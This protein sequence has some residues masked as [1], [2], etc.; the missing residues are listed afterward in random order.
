MKAGRQLHIY[1]TVTNDLTYDQRMH[2]ICGSLAAEGYQVTLVGRKLKT[3]IP[4]E[5][6][7]YKQKR[8]RCFFNKGFLFYKEY[9]IR[10]FFYL[11]SRKM[12]GICAIDLDTIL[13]ALF[14]SKLK[15][16]KRIYDAHEYFTE[17]KEVRTRPLVKWFWTRVEKF[18]IPKFAN[19]YTVSEGLATAFANNYPV[20]YLVIRN[21]PVLAPLPSREKK[22]KFIVY[23]GAVN[24]A[25]GFEYLVPAMKS[26]RYP[27]VVCGDGNFMQQ[28][29][30]LIKQNGV[31]Q[32]VCL[33]GMLLPGQLKELASEATLGIGL[34]E[35][36]GI[37]QL[38]AL[39]NK[40]LEYMHAGLPQVAMN[41]PEY[42]KINDEF[43]IAV[44]LDTLSEQEVSSR[45]N[46]VM[47]DNA[48]LEELQQNAFKA[49]VV[50]CWQNEEKIL[51]N[52][53]KNLF[54]E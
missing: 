54:S 4:L 14:V 10:L 46:Q 19:G 41:F 7:N 47:E 1:F 8:I 43:M 9:N 27:L 21:L 25:R 29:K 24:E 37:N 15:N 44:L 22:G 31:E 42:R 18:A 53:Y 38:H 32:K 49:R 48:L 39:P 20:N 51:L 33:K 16:I 2:R 50:Y 45:I 13:P 17:L 11:L 35:S 34:A 40:F 28:L 5:N 36:E 26:I 52:F 12:D 6:T 23:Q 30:L 3:S